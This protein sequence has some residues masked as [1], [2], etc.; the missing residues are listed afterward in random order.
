LLKS[1]K[2]TG[3]ENVSFS[4]QFKYFTY[5]VLNWPRWYFFKYTQAGNS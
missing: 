5:L 4:I 1:I 3:E 2:K